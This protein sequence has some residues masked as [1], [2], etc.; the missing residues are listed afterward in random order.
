MP[1]WYDFDHYSRYEKR[2]FYFHRTQTLRMLVSLLNQW[3]TALGKESWSYDKPE[4]AHLMYPGEPCPKGWISSIVRTLGSCRKIMHQAYEEF[5]QYFCI[6]E[7][8]PRSSKRAFGDKAY[9]SDPHRLGSDF[10]LL[11]LRIIAFIQSTEE[12]KHTGG[13]KYAFRF[14]AKLIQY[15]LEALQ[16]NHWA[17]C[18]VER[19]VEE[20]PRVRLSDRVSCQPHSA[21]FPCWWAPRAPMAYRS[22]TSGP[23][24]SSR[25]R[26]YC[27]TETS[28]KRKRG[29]EDE[30]SGELFAVELAY[31]YYSREEEPPI[32]E[33]SD[34]DALTGAC[35][36]DLR[37]FE[38]LRPADLHKV[39]KLSTHLQKFIECHF[40]QELQCAEN[41]TKL[42]QD[43]FREE[44]GRVHLQLSSWGNEYIKSLEAD[45]GKLPGDAYTQYMS[46]DFLAVSYPQ[47]YEEYEYYDT[48]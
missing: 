42:L 11:M 15:M 12:Y 27:M 8:V 47:E 33:F 41:A 31:Y 40:R 3:F 29:Q 35:S 28:K 21:I 6:D 14:N 1:M 26:K 30:V 34:A 32:P 7:A 23:A 20:Q 43:F 45:P 25:K 17:Y 48:P 2:I 16:Y 44:H 10:A 4:I 22:P 37:I 9:V 5:V 19:I 18:V 38:L 24:T 39:Q 46:H 36:A 13:L